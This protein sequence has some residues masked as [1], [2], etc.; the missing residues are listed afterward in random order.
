MKTPSAFASLLLLLFLFGGGCTPPPTRWTVLAG[1]PHLSGPWKAAEVPG[2]LAAARAFLQRTAAGGGPQA[3]QA[4]RVLTRWEEY[5]CQVIGYHQDG[6]EMIELSFLP[7][8]L[9]QRV[10]D[11]PS[12]STERQRRPGH[13]WHWRSDYLAVK[14]GG[15]DFW[16]LEYD[17]RTAEFMQFSVNGEA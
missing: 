11:A 3:E 4:R 5:A 7:M 15:D 13:K 10:S 9:A 6:R 12:S 14:D 1:A 17:R 2:L 16:Q 8:S